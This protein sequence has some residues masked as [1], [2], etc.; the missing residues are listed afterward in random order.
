MVGVPCDWIEEIHA[1][2]NDLI[3][4]IEADGSG[5]RPLKAPAEHEPVIPSVTDIVIAVAGIDALGLPLTP[6]WVHRPEYVAELTGLDFGDK[7]KAET[8]AKVLGHPE[9]CGKGCPSGSRFIP[10]LNKVD[11]DYH[12]EKALEVAGYIMEGGVPVVIFTSCLKW[13]VGVDK[14][15]KYC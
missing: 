12:L 13:P 14:L 3:I 10:V 1:C 4:L 11:T 2:F 15:V 9:G 7:I 6:D 8:I 5:G